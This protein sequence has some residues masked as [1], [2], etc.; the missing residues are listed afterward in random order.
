MQCL[1]DD[2]QVLVQLQKDDLSNIL[3]WTIFNTPTETILKSTHSNIRF[4]H[5][6]Y[7]STNVVTDDKTYITCGYCYG[8]KFN[9]LQVEIQ[10]DTCV[11]NPDPTG[12]MMLYYYDTPTT[13]YAS[14]NFL[15]LI[16]CIPIQEL[17]EPNIPMII[18]HLMW[19]SHISDET[20]LENIYTLNENATLEVRNGT[21]RKKYIPQQIDQP[22]Q[23]TNHN[24]FLATFTQLL[25]ESLQ[26]FL[27]HISNPLTIGAGLSGGM[28][29]S[30]VAHRLLLKQNKKVD[31]FSLIQPPP[32]YDSQINRLQDFVEQFGGTFNLTHIAHHPFMTQRPS[33]YTES[34]LNP[35]LEI[36]QEPTNGLAKK[37]RDRGVSVLFTG[38]GGDELFRIDDYERVGFQG[39]SVKSERTND[40]KPIFYSDELIEKYINSPLLEKGYPLPLIPHSLRSAQRVYN[41]IFHSQKIWPI[42]PFGYAP[43]VEFTRS[44]PESLRD[45]KRLLHE[46]QKHHNFPD[47]YIHLQTQ[48]FFTQI[49]EQG[50]QWYAQHYLQDLIE[51]SVLAQ[52]GL[53]L[54]EVI[55][56]DCK[57]NGLK[58]RNQTRLCKYLYSIIEME[59][60]FKPY[61]QKKK[62]G[63]LEND[64]YKSIRASESYQ[65]RYL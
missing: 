62:G 36:Y 25:D 44:L 34:L 14:N 63:D 10:E 19:T 53:I 41:P 7:P 40:R 21:V 26:R 38:F 8:N 60:F 33:P 18:E 56:S 31:L 55:K 43:L 32:Q 54:P 22:K 59:L 65:R 13:L 27:P 49:F 6:E 24:D 12:A 37:C 3:S 64:R 35:Y 29:S 15:A 48:E 28:D 52:Y 51:R 20:I 4:E 9:S 50:M 46:Y 1:V 5:F 58:Y 42:A 39:D 61:E 17:P 45:K 57:E 47:S 16:N 11:I 23:T 2:S 30:T